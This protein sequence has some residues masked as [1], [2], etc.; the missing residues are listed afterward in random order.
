MIGKT[1]EASKQLAF[2]QRWDGKLASALA[3]VEGATNFS[4]HPR[5]GRFVRGPLVKGRKG[6]D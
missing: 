1:G 6:K 3:G 2:V 5:D 4:T